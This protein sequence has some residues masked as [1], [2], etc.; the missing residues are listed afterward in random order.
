MA[1]SKD[2]HHVIAGFGGEDLIGI[3]QVG[4]YG[5]AVFDLDRRNGKVASGAVDGVISWKLIPLKIKENG[6]NVDVAKYFEDPRATFLTIAQAGKDWDAAWTY[7]EIFI[8]RELGILEPLAKLPQDDLRDVQW[9]GQY[10]WACSARGGTHVYSQAGKLMAAADIEE[11]LPTGEWGFVKPISLGAG[12]ML[13]AGAGPLADKKLPG[14]WICV[15]EVQPGNPKLKVTMLMHE[16]NGPFLAGWQEKP[17]LEQ[18]LLAPRGKMRNGDSEVW[19]T[20]NQTQKTVMP[21]IRIDLKTLTLNLYNMGTRGTPFGAWDLKG[22]FLPIWGY[23]D[24]TA[25]IGQDRKYCIAKVGPDSLVD[26]PLKPI[27]EDT[28]KNDLF[29]IY[30]FN[31]KLYI[32]GKTWL[33]IDAQARTVTVLGSGL[34]FGGKSIRDNISYGVSAKLGLCAISAYDGRGSTRSAMIR[35]IHLSTV[36]RSCRKNSG[37]FVE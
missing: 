6:K 33:R 21:I 16:R 28:R 1:I 27:A 35:S 18:P 26:S 15:L 36:R 34:Q 7:N 14:G 8:H 11:G 29:D 5:V 32:P 25:M 12:K 4:G 23:G 3:P 20:Y 24:G 30:P 37:R 31:G 10:L 2:G 9:D 13:L 19:I 17:K 22:A